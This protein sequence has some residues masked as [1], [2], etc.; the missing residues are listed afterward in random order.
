METLETQEVRDDTTDQLVEV[1]LAALL[2]ELAMEI[3]ENP[4][5][6]SALAASPSC[7]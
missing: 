5:L 3:F 6:N 2:D 1:L 7:G 4:K